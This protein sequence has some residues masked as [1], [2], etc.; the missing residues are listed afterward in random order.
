MAIWYIFLRFGILHQE[1]YGNPAPGVDF[2]R[3]H[4]GKTS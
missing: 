1:K 3:L 2:T 4:V